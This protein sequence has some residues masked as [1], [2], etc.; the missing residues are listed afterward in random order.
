MRWRY[1]ESK[2]KANMT[3][4]KRLLLGIYMYILLQW[5]FECVGCVSIVVNFSLSAL[6]YSGSRRVLS[7]SCIVCSVNVLTRAKE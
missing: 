7:V 3:Q 1:L 4:I 6:I 5:I 2:Q